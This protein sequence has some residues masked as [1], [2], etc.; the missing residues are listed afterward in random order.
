[1]K[2]KKKLTL[3]LT[4]LYVLNVLI[5]LLVQLAPAA[6]AA[7]Y[8]PGSTGAVVEEIQAA[9]QAEGYYTGETDGV[10]N[11]ELSEA[12]KAF[13]QDRGLTADGICGAKTLEAMGLSDDAGSGAMDNDAALLAKI[14]SAESRGE[15]FDG[16]VA[17]GAVIM[18]RIKH[19]SFPN[20]LSGVIYQPGAF[21]ALVDGQID[22]AVAESAEK[23]AQEAL[24]GWDPTGGAIYYFN[25]A[26]ATN[27]WIWSRPH[28]IT[29]GKHR[30]CS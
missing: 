30:F 10:Y 19:P 6:D 28:L 9:L 21:T 12:V 4:V 22:E 14:I 13:Q 15:P 24:N 8:K 25:P 16:Q 5:I 2:E 3:S 29:I 20:S 1:M 17:V 18:N 27:Q 11:D 7:S 26:T 23:A